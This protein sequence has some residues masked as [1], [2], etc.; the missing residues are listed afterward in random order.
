M[1]FTDIV[2][3]ETQARGV[4]EIP[5]GSAP[6]SPVPPG[7]SIVDALA[8]IKDVTDQFAFTVANQVDANALS[9]GGLDS[10]GVRTAVGLDSANLDTQLTGINTNIDANET[11]IDAV[12]TKVSN[13]K[14]TVDTNLNAT[15]SSRATPAQVATELG[16]YDAPTNA[17][18]LAAFLVIKGAGFAGTDT[19]E[20]IRDA[21]TDVDTVVDAVLVDTGTTLDQALAVVDGIVD[22]ILID[23]AEIGV[24]G[25][26]LT[27]RASQSDLTLVKAK[28]DPIT[29]TVANQIDSNALTGG[30]GGGGGLDAAG[31]R[32]AIGLAL[33]NLDTQLTGINTNIDSNESKIDIVDGLIDE[34]KVVVD[35]FVFTIANQVDSNAL[36]G[37]GT[38]L[39]A[40]ETRT[41]LGMATANLDDQLDGIAGDIS[42][43]TTPSITV[44]SPVA[45]G[46][47]IVMIAGYDYTVASGRALE[48]ALAGIPDLTG[49]TVD[50]VGD[51]EEEVS[52]GWD[53][54]VLG[55]GGATQ[56]I[57]AQV[58]ESQTVALS[59]QG[60]QAAYAFR[61]KATL[62]NGSQI[63]LVDA[64]MVIK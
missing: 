44:T 22:A 17:E 4:W 41:A 58:T 61:I 29:F 9:G 25:A 48:W 24:A 62:A 50:L 47:D 2:F 19:L 28:T 15:I 45:A 63:A 34:I 49:A 46:G 12:D 13:V 6:G 14:T 31:V 36:T 30:G 57:R 54:S 26:G 8:A 18:M 40:S 35:K 60:S 64:V 16:T 56:T 42:T 39:S 11:K 59:A 1:P 32:A 7:I 43:I 27:S 55:A 37:G 21:I 33:A 10:A 51:T 53:I 38:G 3:S 5:I 52:F 20:A 23:T